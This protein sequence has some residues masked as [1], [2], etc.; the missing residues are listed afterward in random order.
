MLK[1]GC[2][3]L[4][5][6]GAVKL[7]PLVWTVAVGSSSLVLPEFRGDFSS[8]HAVRGVARKV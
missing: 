5:V 3:C 7:R 4:C 2:A 6:K 8:R 1:P